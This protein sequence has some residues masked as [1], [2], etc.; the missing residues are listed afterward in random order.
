MAVC[1]GSRVCNHQNFTLPKSPFAVTRGS[2]GCRYPLTLVPSQLRFDVADR[3]RPESLN[4][5]TCDAARPLARLSEMPP[6]NAA[7]EAPLLAPLFGGC[8]PT[9]KPLKL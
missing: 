7:N 8:S 1:H 5:P 3:G 2:Q 6:A 9:P 4:R